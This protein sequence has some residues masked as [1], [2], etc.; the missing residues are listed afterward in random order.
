MKEAWQNNVSWLNRYERKTN[1]A[2]VQL[3]LHTF[4]KKLRDNF[5]QIKYKQVS[6]MLLIKTVIV[7]RIRMK[8]IER[9]LINKTLSK[10]FSFNHRT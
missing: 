7:N 10:L 5:T 2:T 6:R 4:E 8:Y 3:F 1:E 9:M